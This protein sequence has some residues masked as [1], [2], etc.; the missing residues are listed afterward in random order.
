LKFIEAD[1]GVA[2]LTQ[3][4]LNTT[5]LRNA[6]DFDD[7]PRRAPNLQPRQCPVSAPTAPLVPDAADDD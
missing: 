6:F 4:D 7:R 5:D 1:F 3:R 2:H